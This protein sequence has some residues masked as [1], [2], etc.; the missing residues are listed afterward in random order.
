[1]TRVS[2]KYF[3]Y[4]LYYSRSEKVANNKILII[5]YH[6]NQ[7]NKVNTEVL[8]CLHSYLKQVFVLFFETSFTYL[9]K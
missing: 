2:N 9:F 4:R 3:G 5:V 7:H 6:V 8:F 1:M